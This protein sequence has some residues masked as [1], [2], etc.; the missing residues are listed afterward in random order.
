MTTTFN[1]YSLYICIHLPYYQH[2]TCMVLKA[3]CL[4]NKLESQQ[5]I[6][7]T[8]AYINSTSIYNWSDAQVCTYIMSLRQKLQRIYLRCCQTERRAADNCINTRPHLSACHA[9]GAINSR[10]KVQ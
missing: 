1:L 6:Q 5:T 4:I 2:I 8:Q 9:Y 7:L 3:G 10:P